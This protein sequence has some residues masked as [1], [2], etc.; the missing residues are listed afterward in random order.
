MQKNFRKWHTLKELLHKKEKVIYFK[1]RE[2]WWCSL[3]V[4]VGFEQDGKNYHFERPVLILKKFG[5][6]LMWVLPT[7]SKLKEGKYYYLLEDKGRKHS[8]IL[9]QLRVISSKRLLRKIRKISPEDFR[10]IRNLI[11]GFL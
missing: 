3:G 6:D 10:K 9:S 2:I 5:K 8:I 1:E 7:T 11:N 4:N